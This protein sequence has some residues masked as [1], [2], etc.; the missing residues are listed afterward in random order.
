MLAGAVYRPLAEMVPVVTAPP[1]FPFTSQ[2]MVVLL[3]P[4]TEL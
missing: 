4:V 1:I 2:S 3:V